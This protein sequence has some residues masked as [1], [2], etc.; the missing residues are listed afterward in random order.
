MGQLKGRAA[1]SRRRGKKEGGR[2][3]SSGGGEAWVQG[4]GMSSSTTSGQ[5]QG[6][7][8][9][10]LV[11]VVDCVHGMV[12]A[13]SC[14]RWNKH[15][16]AVV[17]LSE[18]GIV[19]TV[20]ESG[21]LQAKVYLKT[22]LFAEYDYGAEGRPRFGLSLGLLV[23]CLNMF[24]VPG[25]ASPVGIRYPGPDMQ[26]L[27][28]SKFKLVLDMDS[29]I[30]KESIDDL[31][32]PGSSIQ[33]HF[34]PDPPSVIFKGEGHGDL[35]IEFS[36]Y[37]NTDLLIAFQCDQELS[38]RYKYKFLRATTSN[39]PSS[40]LK[41]H[42]GSKFTIGRGGM[43]K[44]PHLVS[45]ARLGTQSYHNFAG[46]AQQPSRIAFIEFFVKPEEDD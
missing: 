17:E 2:R 7:D 23:D 42:R 25:F 8:A 14:V 33:I 12:D 13:L 29:A 3:D 24:T 30:L 16:G 44:I 22:E 31:E 11:C 6:D 21:C 36:Y 27:L 19:V 40:V 5:G 35:E 34:H 18:R 37:A 41:E 43:L 38:Y 1:A 4:A 45:V 28:S 10:D 26:L 46:G 32:W 15:Q 9:P 39:V 20:E